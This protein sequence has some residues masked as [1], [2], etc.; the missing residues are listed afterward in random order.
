MHSNHTTRYV[1]SATPEQPLEIGT[2]VNYILLD[3][4]EAGSSDIHIEPWE[5]TLVVRIR[6]NGQLRILDYLPQEMADKIFGRI[7]VMADLPSFEKGVPMDGRAPTPPEFGGV[8]L[9]ISIMPLIKGEKAV[10][11]I[12]DP[13]KRKFDLRQLGFEDSTLDHYLEMLQK[14]SG[15]ILL[16]GP[17]G[18]G[19]TTAI[20]ASLY[21]L[22]QKHGASISISTVEDP[23]EAPLAMIS[24]AQLNPAQQFTYPVALRSLLRQDPEV[25]MIGEIRDPDTAS[26]A[27][28]AGLTG[29]L[30]ISTIHSG[31]T[32]GIYARMINMGMEPFLLCSSVVGVLGVRLVRKNCDYCSVPYAPPENM[33]Q[34]FSEEILSEAQ[35]RRGDGCDQCGGSGYAGR[36][37]ITELLTPSEGLRDAILAK[38]PTRALMEIAIQDGMRTLYDNGIKRVFG[39]ETTFEEVMSVCSSDMM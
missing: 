20:Y 33:L 10:L 5:G 14:P 36:T 26:I 32:A 21:Y 31:S 22:T 34:S 19:K 23:V 38:K 24:Q 2:L 8:T 4:V 16:N 17:T 13:R 18:S 1:Q 11:R 7:K 25:I 39:G 28:Q 12:F 27:V 37:A 9:R 29:H 15:L 6:V 30:V 35:F 3:A